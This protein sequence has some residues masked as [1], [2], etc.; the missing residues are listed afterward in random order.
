MEDKKSRTIISR[1]YFYV[2]KENLVYPFYALFHI[3]FI[4]SLKKTARK[5]SEKVFT[6]L[7]F[8]HSDPR[9]AQLSR[10]YSLGCILSFFNELHHLFEKAEVYFVFRL[11]TGNFHLHFIAETTLTCTAAG[12]Y[13]KVK[14]FML[15]RVCKCPTEEGWKMLRPGIGQ[16]QFWF[17]VCS[18]TW[19]KKSVPE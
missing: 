6:N 16:R 11:T 12:E 17:C 15:F 4:P 2:C 8:S 3:K 18:S 13:Q 19:L 7:Q 10:M 1:L 9:K 5:H 14:A